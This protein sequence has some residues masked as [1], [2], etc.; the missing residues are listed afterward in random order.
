MGSFQFVWNYFLYLKFI[1]ML[2]LS[3]DN[4][5]DVQW[6]ERTVKNPLLWFVISEVVVWSNMVELPCGVCVCVGRQQ[7]TVGPPRP[8]PE[9]RRHWR[10]FLLL[11]SVLCEAPQETTQPH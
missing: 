2:T 10:V 11:Y 3:S 6:I 1:L 9:G 4:T 5:L 7:R 8:A